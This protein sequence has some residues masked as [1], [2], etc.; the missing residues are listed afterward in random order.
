MT[1]IRGQYEE[2]LCGIHTI[3]QGQ[4]FVLSLPVVDL[5][6]LVKDQDRGNIDTLNE[7]VEL[8]TTERLVD[9]DR[10]DAIL[11]CKM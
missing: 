6:K 11:L 2:L 7:R 10:C 4:N 9:H 1:V 8:I 5:L 3:E